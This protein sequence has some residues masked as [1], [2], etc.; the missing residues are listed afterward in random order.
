MSLSQHY[1]SLFSFLVNKE[2]NLHLTKLP[3]SQ[4]KIIQKMNPEEKQDKKFQGKK[5]L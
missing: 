2:V 3:A 1:L 4:H 5:L